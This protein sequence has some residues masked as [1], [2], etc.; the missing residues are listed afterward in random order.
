M[1]TNENSIL[2]PP[3]LYGLAPDLEVPLAAYPPHLPADRGALLADHVLRQGAPVRD[4][5]MARANAY[6]VAFP[7][8]NPQDCD[9]AAVLDLVLWQW[10]RQVTSSTRWDAARKVADLLTGLEEVAQ[11]V[12][13]SMP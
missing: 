8:W 2:L 5:C 4:W 3:Q 7:R 9:H 11:S 6:F 12:K 10:A 13:G 1:K